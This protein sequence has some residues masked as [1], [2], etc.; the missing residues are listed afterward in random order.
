MDGR[1]PDRTINIVSGPVLGSVVQAGSIT[2]DVH[3]HF[4]HRRTV[5]VRGRAAERPSWLARLPGGPAGV[6]LDARRVLVPGSLPEAGTVVDLPFAG[7]FTTAARPVLRG[8]AATVLELAEPVEV[9]GAPLSAPAS[10]AG[11]EFVTHGFP[12]GGEDIAPATGVLDGAAGPGGQWFAVR[13]GEERWQSDAGFT[14]APVF[15]R[16]ADAVVGLLV[17]GPDGATVLP[18][19]VLLESWPWLRDL[20]GWRLDHDPALR[21]HWLPRARGSEVESDTGAWYFTGRIEARRE[22]CAWLGGTG[23]PLLVVTGGPGTGKSALLAHILVS[24]DPRWAASTADDGPRPA[25]GAVDVA[26]H[27]KGLTLDD[28]V[29]RLAALAD[30]RASDPGELLVALR[31]RR[32]AAGRPVTVLCDALDEVVTVE[33]SL[34][35][36]RLLSEL[37]GAGVARIVVGVRTAP[38]GSLRARVA[39]VWGRSAPV[40]DLESDRYLRREDITEYVA[41]RLAGDDTG[42]RYR[43]APGLGDIA[44]AVAERSRHN[45]LVAQ[46]TSRWLLLPGTPVPGAGPAGELPSTVGEA[47]EKYLDAFGPDR[48]TVERVLTALAFAAGGG[49]PRNDLW[50]RLAEALS[51]GH[52]VT[53]ADLSRVFDSAASYLI[54]TAVRADGTPAYRLYHEVLDEHLRENCVVR[55]PHRVVF[56][57]LR[58]TVPVREGRRAWEDADPYVRAQLA[59]HAARADA[60]DEL[61]ADGGF[62]VYAEPGPLLAVLPEAATARGRLAVACYRASSADHRHLDPPARARVLALDAARLGA[63]DLQAQ[64]ARESSAWRVRFATGARQHGAL[65]ATLRTDQGN[66]SSIVAGT[67]DG[68]AVALSGSEGGRTRLWDVADQRPIGSVIR[69]LPW[70]SYQSP[71]LALAAV[72]GRLLGLAA[73]DNLVQVWDLLQARLLAERETGPDD[74]VHGLAVTDLDGRPVW[75]T[76]GEEGLRV[77]DLRTHDLVA[78]PVGER[79]YA[80]AVTELDGTPVAVTGGPS[81]ARVWDLRSLRELGDPMPGPE[82]VFQVAVAEVAGRPV[83]L[84]GSGDRD[85]TLRL[86]DL[87]TRRPIGQPRTDHGWSVSGIAV[88]ELDGRPVAVT[89]SGHH[90]PGPDDEDTTLLVWDLPEWRLLGRLAGHTQG[91]QCVAVTEVDGRPVAVT[92]GG[93]EGTVRLWDLT[94]AD[95]RLGDPAPGHG[96]HILEL[97]VL[98]RDGHR[99]AVSAGLDKTAFVWDLEARR[100]LAR[101]PVGFTYVTAIEES[102]GRPLVLLAGIGFARIHDVATGSVVPLHTRDPDEPPYAATIHSGAVARLD[103]RPVVALVSAGK[104]LRLHDFATGEVVAGPMAVALDDDRRDSVDEPCAVALLSVHGR[105]CAVVLSGHRDLGHTFITGLW[106]LGT[107]ALLANLDPASSP[108]VTTAFVNG[109][110]VV[111][112]T[113]PEGALRVWDATE[114]RP[115]RTIP[116]GARD[117]QYLTAGVLGN[118]P[119]VLASGDDGPVTTWD[120]T[121]GTPRDEIRLPATCRGLALGERGTLVVGLQNDIA[122]FD[123]ELRGLVPELT[124]PDAPGG[125]R[126]GPRFRRFR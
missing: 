42:G 28:V 44:V 16:D 57:A 51:P 122:V 70:S 96:R 121:T 53:A 5:S 93:W 81:G 108:A 115:L 17:P 19:A 113:G 110:P 88:T 68:R 8:P 77:W 32:E 21:T 126:R 40:V 52:S 50:A 3:V 106:D 2:G 59:G 45:F 111:V 101:A 43:D 6:L 12:G 66:V 30:V 105:A 92:G 56:E 118:R 60:L 10:C 58:E 35:I 64:F 116:T 20:L 109:R 49:L 84:T 76:V 24:A 33:E 98:D 22:I 65:L 86:W 27:L 74:M 62:L 73:G 63:A 103:G 41:R 78:G 54:E 18:L 36:A 71:E 123:T 114:R 26:V 34:R 29:E 39:R 11:H 1:R 4:P 100:V 31:D 85:G 7:V 79:M 125:A 83:V 112:T 67:H 25:P 117:L 104:V 95:Q 99:L 15:D 38:P 55:A 75:I 13:R 94:L 37:A 120:L 87:R 61:L 124:S 91:T 72:D 46:L 47:M 9:P 90:E 69:G 82:S 97:A 107:G 80:V 23:P 89:S 102:G 14:G 119:V 48:G